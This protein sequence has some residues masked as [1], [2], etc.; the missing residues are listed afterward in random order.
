MERRWE[1]EMPMIAA[2]NLVKEF[3]RTKPVA[4]RLSTLRTLF[5]RQQEVIRAVDGVTLAVDEG[6]IVGYLG[7]NGAGKSTTI[8]MLTGIL[9]PSGGTVEVLG[10]DPA[11]QRKR[12]ARRIGVVFGQ[13][14]QLWWDL[15]LRD[16][17]E[18]LRHMYRVPEPRFRENLAI[19]QEVLDLDPFLDSP[20]RQ[21]SLGQRMRGDLAA[22]IL[23]D[24]ALL[25]LDEPTIGL[26]LLAKDHIRTF[27][28]RYNEERGVTMLLT[29]H[30]LGDIEQLCDRV[31]VIDHGRLQ[32]DG[33]ADALRARFAHQIEIAADFAAPPDLEAGKAET[34]R[35]ARETDQRWRLSFDAAEWT[36]GS[37]VRWLTTRGDLRDISIEEMSLEHV[38]RQMY[39][40]A[41]V[42]TNATHVE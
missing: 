42:T 10:F 36:A 38:I 39:R 19:A 20:V 1:D 15:P 11:R 21:L 27:L 33:D 32:F 2:D 26:D 16:S 28:R 30:D 4:G 13:R 35:I 8:K 9:V 6:E 12:L 5:T 29:T 18:L 41:S 24:P 14:T 7:P 34:M 40:G 17:L 23:H 31:I 3:T 22:A 37:A 25:V